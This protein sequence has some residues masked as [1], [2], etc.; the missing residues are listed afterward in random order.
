MEI[1]NIIV[2]IAGIGSF[3]VSL[4]TLNK[5]LK[6]NVKIDKSIKIDSHEKKSNKSKIKGDG[7]N[8]SQS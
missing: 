4:I 3:I 8:V 6:I 1:F 7:N 5:V 2:G